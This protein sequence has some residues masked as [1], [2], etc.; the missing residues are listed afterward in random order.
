VEGWA[1]FSSWKWCWLATANRPK[2]AKQSR[3]IHGRLGISDDQLI[4]GAY[5]D[6]CKRQRQTAGTAAGKSAIDP[7]WF[8]NEKPVNGGER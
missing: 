8:P 5:I 2:Q 7:A 6:C 1:I 4:E 3:G